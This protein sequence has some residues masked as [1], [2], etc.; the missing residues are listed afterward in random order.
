MTD[1]AGLFLN[2]AE[3]HRGPVQACLSGFSDMDLHFFTHEN[4]FH[5]GANFFPPAHHI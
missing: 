1:R 2:W 4:R 5:Q 3:A